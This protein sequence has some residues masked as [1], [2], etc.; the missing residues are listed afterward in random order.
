MVDTVA[1][2]LELTGADSMTLV[3]LNHS[4][5][6]DAHLGFSICPSI[7]HQS[8]SHIVL[9]IIAVTADCIFQKCL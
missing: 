5:F 7:Y 6:R 4:Y 8:I 3:F 9:K 2:G 1:T